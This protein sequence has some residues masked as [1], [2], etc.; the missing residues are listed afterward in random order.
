[1][2]SAFE[3][4]KLK[5]LI[6]LL[7]RHQSVSNL[8]ATKLAKLVYYIDAEAMRHLGE[9]VTASDFIKHEHGPVPSRLERALKQLRRAEAIRI[10]GQAF[11]DYELQKVD[12]LRDAD[13]TRFTNDELAIIDR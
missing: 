3:L 10:D 13:R 2:V 1:M 7:A 5:E 4:D 12:A 6:V 8:G 9:S 11:F